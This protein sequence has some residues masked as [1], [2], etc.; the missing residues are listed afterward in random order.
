VSRPQRRIARALGARLEAWYAESGRTFPWRS[1]RDPYRVTVT[2]VLLQ[3]TRAAVA[4]RFLRTFFEKYASWAELARA[5]QD[6]LEAVLRPI[7]LHRRRAQ[8]LRALAATSIDRTALTI[9][10]EPGVG[11]YVARAIRVSIRGER[12]AMVDTNFVRLVHRIFD[13]PWRA[14]YRWDP[15]LQGIARTVVDSAKDARNVNWAVLDFGA[16]VCRP[17]NPLCNSCPLSDGCAYAANAIAAL[18]E[19]VEPRRRKQ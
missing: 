11:Q 6:E 2:E 19:S 18:G 17:R 3:R 8:T 4:E 1:W 13:G 9:E 5:P 14:D 15:R 16:L 12:L 10:G 7:G